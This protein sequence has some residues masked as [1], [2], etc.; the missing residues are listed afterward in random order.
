MTKIQ[1]DTEAKRKLC[2]QTDPLT[3]VL[4]NFLRVNAQMCNLT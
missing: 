4:P 3:A 1:A 2:S